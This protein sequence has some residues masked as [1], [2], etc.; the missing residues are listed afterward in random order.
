MPIVKH[1]RNDVENNPREIRD[2][3]TARY[4]V[5][6]WQIVSDVIPEIV[7][8]EPVSTPVPVV[9]VESPLEK[10]EKAVDAVVDAPKAEPEQKVK[11]PYKHR[12]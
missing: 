5:D 6:G 11:R 9:P 10:I 1:N 3:E 12:R 8:Q 7:K 2:D 4:L